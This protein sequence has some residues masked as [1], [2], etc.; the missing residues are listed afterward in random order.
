M[1]HSMTDAPCQDAG[2]VLADEVDPRRFGLVQSRPPRRRRRGRSFHVDE[3]ARAAAR[4]RDLLIAEDDC[5][6]VTGVGVTL[7][8]QKSFDEVP[9]VDVLWVP[10][11][12]PSALNALD[13][14]SA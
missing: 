3:I 11:G 5:N 14:I 9:A 8:P 2:H 4:L 10:G 12:D 6:V 13:R 1:R 7:K